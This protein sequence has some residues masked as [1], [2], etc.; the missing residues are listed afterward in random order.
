MKRRLRLH[1]HQW[2]AA[3]LLIALPFISNGSF[4]RHVF[5]VL[6]SE[7]DENPS[8]CTADDPRQ[9]C[10]NPEASFDFDDFE[11]DS[12]DYDDEFELACVDDEEEC[13]Y[14]SRIGECD[15]NP[16]YMLKHCKLSCKACD[17]E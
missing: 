15:S 10:T 6:A 9:E 5:I 7:A 13:K 3:I 1:T 8:L 16:N 2:A 4:H 11:D 17:N 12:E 14:W